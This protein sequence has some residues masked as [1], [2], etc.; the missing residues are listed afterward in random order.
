VV[1]PRRDFNRVPID[2]PP[3]APERDVLHHLPERRRAAVAAFLTELVGECPYC[4]GAVTRTTS[5]GI[6]WQERLGCSGCVAALVGSCSLCG[7]QMTRQDKPAEDY[8]ALTHVKCAEW[9]K[10][11]R[12]R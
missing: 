10:R 1:A 8:D 4:G 12:G 11:R 5:R 9:E 3:G 2:P 7:E 6:D